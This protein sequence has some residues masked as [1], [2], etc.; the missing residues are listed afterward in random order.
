MIIV[1]GLLVRDDRKVLMR[2]RPTT[3]RMPGL[4]EYPAGSTNFNEATRNAIVRVWRKNFGLPIQQDKI[5]WCAAHQLRAEEAIYVQMFR[6]EPLG[7]VKLPEPEDG[8]RFDWID[9]HR[10]IHSMALD[11]IACWFYQ[12]VIKEIERPT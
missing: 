11:P 7:E 9:P 5:A 2:R 3:G 1:A 4:W 8:S 6:V 12:D 10:A